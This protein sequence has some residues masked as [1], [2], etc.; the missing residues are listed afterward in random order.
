MPS[1]DIVGAAIGPPGNDA[2]SAIVRHPWQTSELIFGGGV[3]VKRFVAAPAFAHTFRN[4]FGIALEGS[5]RFG[6]PLAQVVRVLLLGGTPGK[7]K[8]ENN[9]E[10]TR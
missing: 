2:I 10:R 6:S 5:G 4:C 8:K 3:E 7:Q 1:D 9:G